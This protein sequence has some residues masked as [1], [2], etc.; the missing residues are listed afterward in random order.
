MSFR[1]CATRD[2]PRKPGVCKISGRAQSYESFKQ[3]RYQGAVEPTRQLEYRL[4]ARSQH[5]LYRGH[6]PRGLG[7]AVVPERILRF[8]RGCRYLAGAPCRTNR[9]TPLVHQHHLVHRDPPEYRYHH[10][11][12]TDGG[13]ENSSR[14]RSEETHVNR[15]PRARSSS[16]AA[17]CSARTALLA[18][19]GL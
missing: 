17:A 18:A 1:G 13:V 2:L 3:V 5:L 11:V 15:L 4:Q 14:M 16:G 6:A 7:Q 12:A 10:N 8:R 9:R 19:S